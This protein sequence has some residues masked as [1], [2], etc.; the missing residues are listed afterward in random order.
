MTGADHP[1]PWVLASEP[2]SLGD[3]TNLVTLVNGQTFCLSGRSGDFSA[4]PTHGVFFA[5]MRVLSLAQL[6]VNGSPVEPLAVSLGDASSATFVGRSIPAVHTDQRMLVIRRRRL[7]SVW[8]EDLEFM[9][10][11]SAPMSVTVE[12]EVAA[13]FADVYALKEGRTSSEGQH[14]IEV[15]PDGLL[16]GWRLGSLHRTAA[17]QVG[18]VDVEVSTRGFTWRLDMSGHESRVVE[19]DLSVALGAS[20]IERRHH[21]PRLPFASDRHRAWVDGVPRLRTS[22]RAWSGA[23]ERSVADVAALRLH[24]PSAERRPVIAAG[25][26]WYMTL[27]GRDALI[28]SYMAM[29]IDAELALGVLDALAE[30]QGTKVDDATE[31]QPGRI[32]HETRSLDVAEPTLTGGSTYFGSVDSTPLFVVVLGELCRWGLSAPD[33]QRLLPHADRALTWMAEF[34]DRDGD[35]FI[36]YQRLSER[37]LVNQGWKDSVDAIRRRDGSIVEAPIA[38]AE[39]QGYA[40]A[41]H[42]ARAAI[43]DRLGDIATAVEQRAL[44]ERL[45]RRFDEA[46]WMPELGWYATALGPDKEQVGSLTSNIGHCLWTGIADES[47][48]QQVVDRLMAPDMF[49]GWG[50]RT[51]GANEAAYDPMSYHC[52]TVWPHDNALIA[53]GLR[54]YG[55][56]DAVRAVADGLFAA[57]TSWHGRLPE[58][59]AGLDRTQVDTPIPFPTSCSPQAWAA[60]APFLLL[61]TL[62]GLEPTDDGLRVA[63]VAGAFDN[64]MFLTGVRWSGMTFD[65]RVTNGVASVVSAAE[66]GVR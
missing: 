10:T 4:N 23:Y 5:D 49:N 58:L 13:D 2:R 20:W 18:G 64:D 7:G 12:L 14:A 43:A 48:T 35:G 16:F 44:A 38:L 29:H 63:A 25:A 17:L 9:T 59:F 30:L 66:Q 61:R 34:G 47:R 56:D 27:F 51:M 52:G 19:L 31:E 22:N 53:A 62:L 60:T 21:R 55:F 37:G 46:F 39:V 33:L 6:L 11:G 1:S 42:Q 3:P 24:D 45:R 32:L 65:I 40:Y 26:P 36:E 54:R 15:Q 57:A 50:I 8:H 28:S 41:A